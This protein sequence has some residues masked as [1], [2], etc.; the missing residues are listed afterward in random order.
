MKQAIESDRIDAQVIATIGLVGCILLVAIVVAL[1]GATDWLEGQERSAKLETGAVQVSAS[2]RAE[3]EGKLQ[4][5]RWI[6]R[7]QGI[8]AVPLDTAMELVIERYRG[9]EGA[10]SESSRADG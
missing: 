4:D 6:D 9:R 7:E 1:Q 2:A 3:Q 10:A 5:L 8:A